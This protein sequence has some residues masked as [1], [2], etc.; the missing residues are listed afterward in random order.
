VI[1]DDEMVARTVALTLEDEHDVEVC[2]DPRAAVERVRGGQRYDVVLCDLMMPDLD[3][4]RVHAELTAIDP[5][6]DARFVVMTGGALSSESETFL[7]AMAPRRISKPFDL[8]GLRSQVRK[9]VD[10]G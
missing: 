3:G 5:A 1:D 10:R 9:I 8:P 7:A 2:T 4:R 6:I